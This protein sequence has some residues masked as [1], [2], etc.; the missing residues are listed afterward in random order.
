MGEVSG[1]DGRVRYV[2]G[3]LFSEREETKDRVILIRKNRPEWQKGKWNAIGGKVEEGESV[4]AAMTREFEEEAGLKVENWKKFCELSGDGYQVDFFVAY[5]KTWHCKAMTDEAIQ[6]FKT[7]ELPE[8]VIPNL[9]WLIPMAANMEED[10]ALGYTV[11][12]V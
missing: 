12:E 5:G 10:S 6:G 11:E 3:F 1:K 4:Y 2:A 8:D 7:S 9:R